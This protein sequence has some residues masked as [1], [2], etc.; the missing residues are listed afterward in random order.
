MHITSPC[1]NPQ[2]DSAPGFSPDPDPASDPEAFLFLPTTMSSEYRR[3]VHPKY[4]LPGALLPPV[5][6]GDSSSSAAQTHT[7]QGLRDA[8]M[9]SFVAVP[10]RKA[11]SS[12]YRP[13]PQFSNSF[14][15]LASLKDLS[16]R[17]LPN[18]PSPLANGS[19]TAPPN[20]TSTPVSSRSDSRSRPGSPAALSPV[21]ELNSPRSPT[22]AAASSGQTPPYL[23]NMT[24]KRR[25]GATPSSATPPPPGLMNRREDKKKD[26]VQASP[27]FLDVNNTQWREN[28][29]A[30]DPTAFCGPLSHAGSQTNSHAGSTT[31]FDKGLAPRA[32]S[33]WMMSNNPISLMQ[34]PLRTPRKFDLD[35]MPHESDSDT[36][37]E[38]G[39]SRRGFS[40]PP[41]D[42]NDMDMDHRQPLHG[43][44]NDWDGDNQLNMLMAITRGDIQSPQTPINTQGPFS[45]D[46]DSPGSPPPTGHTDHDAAPQ[47]VDYH[48][49]IE[50]WDGEVASKASREQKIR[51]FRSKLQDTGKVQAPAARSISVVDATQH[52]KSNLISNVG[53]QIGSVESRLSKKLE[54]FQANLEA[55]I[56]LKARAKE[57]VAAFKKETLSS[58]ETFNSQ[59][60]HIRTIQESSEAIDLLDERIRNCR[61]KVTEYKERLKIVN[62]WID[63][64]ERFDRL[65]SRRKRAAFKITM[66]VL[67]VILA[68]SALVFAVATTR[69]GV[70]KVSVKAVTLSKQS[71]FDD[72]LDCLGDF[73][74]CRFKN[75]MKE[76]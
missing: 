51:E 9:A 70:K 28:A 29:S 62:Q 22:A 11:T 39:R 46:W 64:Q 24:M 8:K 3:S 45:P 63:E 56:D 16:D 14:T 25:N 36:D 40:E 74:H 7:N 61:A 71:Q 53:A 50:D 76:L 67:I 18:K 26:D 31:G 27:R 13:Q 52:M 34:H 58:Y 33:S 21:D 66:S 1:I 55:L 60:E 41:F 17:D 48:A 32:T 44:D 37:S 42:S 10:D 23:R 12:P 2:P 15:S 73:D 35:V 6:L 68:I 54:L 20:G 75:D 43:L 5:N 72:V 65:W 4:K 38:S 49:L 30:F 59:L 19:V 57:T 47:L 69:G